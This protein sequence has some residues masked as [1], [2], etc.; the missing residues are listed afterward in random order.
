MFEEF[1][2]G[3]GVVNK[4]VLPTENILVV[5]KG[6]NVMLNFESEFEKA[7]TRAVAHGLQR[8]SKTTFI[9]WEDEHVV[10]RYDVSNEKVGQVKGWKILIGYPRNQGKS[11]LNLRMSSLQPGETG[12]RKKKL[13]HSF[14]L[15]G[16]TF[17][18]TVRLGWNFAKRF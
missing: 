17:D 8:N 2:G 18:P 6:K 5:V 11:N 13:I 10:C 12:A 15:L 3:F 14:K 16:M 1:Q 7:T 9:V 4:G